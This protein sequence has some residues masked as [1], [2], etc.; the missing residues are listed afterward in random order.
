LQGLL[1]K[2]PEELARWALDQ[3]NILSSDAGNLESLQVFQLARS[4]G[5][6]PHSQKQ[7]RVRNVIN[8]F[9]RLPVH[10][11]VAAVSKVVEMGGS[12]LSISEQVEHGKQL[13]QANVPT[14]STLVKNAK[15]LLQVAKFNEMSKDDVT[16]IAQVAQSAASQIARPDE[17]VALVKGLQPQERQRLTDALVS[18][19]IVPNEQRGVLEDVIKPGGYVERL[20]IAL[21]AVD[22]VCRFRYLVIFFLPFVE[23]VCAWTLGGQLCGTLL[24]WWLRA[25]ALV[26]LFVAAAICYMGEKLLPAYRKLREDPLG[27]SQHWQTV[28]HECSDWRTRLDTAVPGVSVTAYQAA[29]TGALVGIVA[30]CLGVLWALVGIFELLAERNSQ[31]TSP[32]IFASKFFVAIRLIFGFALMLAAGLAHHKI[33]RDGLWVVPQHESGVLHATGG[34]VHETK[35]HTAAHRRTAANPDQQARSMPD[36][37]NSKAVQP[38]S[39]RPSVRRQATVGKGLDVH[40][41]MTVDHTSI[42]ERFEQ[43]ERGRKG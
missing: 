38:D 13:Q 36:S 8:G 30:T 32:A 43:F 1:D 2:Q 28:R 11:R 33:Q 27:L 15:R 22:L 7:E 14:D 9:G 26:T 39:K 17:V 4:L 29:A 20:S 42:L 23:F 10:E 18:A 24:I 3:V 35:Q 25:D 19:N 5:A 41:Q 6:A 16:S 40:R 34:L 31:C 21:R 37:A 12:A